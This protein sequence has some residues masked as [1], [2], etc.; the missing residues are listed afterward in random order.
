MS[1][2]QHVKHTIAYKYDPYTSSLTDIFTMIDT[3][4]IHYRYGD[5]IKFLNKYGTV[6]TEKTARVRPMMTQRV[7]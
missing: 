2:I 5:Y 3:F 7:H 1:T 6:D 4:N